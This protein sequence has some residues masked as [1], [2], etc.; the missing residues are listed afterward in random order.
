M[1]ENG[2][3][4]TKVTTTGPSDILFGKIGISNSGDIIKGDLKFLK[5]NRTLSS[6]GSVDKLT[7]F[8]YNKSW[9]FYS[10][11]EN[12]KIPEGYDSYILYYENN[13]WNYQVS[14]LRGKYSYIAW[15]NDNP[16]GYSRCWVNSYLLSDTNKS[17]KVNATFYFFKS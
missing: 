14:Y 11:M 10:W 5:E 4:L 6:G 16:Y 12:I 7:L 8:A 9:E 17:I 1:K 15:N 2:K 3:D 13:G